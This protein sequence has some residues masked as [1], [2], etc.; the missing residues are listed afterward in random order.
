MKY[1][2]LII[3]EIINIHTRNKDKFRKETYLQNTK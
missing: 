1:A 2:F 3:N